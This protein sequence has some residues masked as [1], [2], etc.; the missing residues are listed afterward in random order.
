MQNWPVDRPPHKQSRSSKL[1]VKPT[2]SNFCTPSISLSL[3]HRLMLT[4]RVLVKLC[5]TRSHT[6]WPPKLRIA[7]LFLL[8]ILRKWLSTRFLIPPYNSKPEA[9]LNHNSGWH[10]RCV[11]GPLS[12]LPSASPSFNSPRSSVLLWWPCLGRAPCKETPKR[13]LV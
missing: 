8:A 12:L 9:S 10:W 1:N 7:H 3:F 2:S 4:S 13:L 6:L 11:L 5:P